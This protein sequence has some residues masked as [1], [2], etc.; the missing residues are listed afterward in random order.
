MSSLCGLALL[1]AGQHNRLL[2]KVSLQL[3]SRQVLLCVSQSEA[4]EGHSGGHVVQP[5]AAG[6]REAPIGGGVLHMQ[7]QVGLV[8]HPERCA[9]HDL[10]RPA[11]RMHLHT[12][13]GS[14]Q[15]RLLC[16]CRLLTS[17]YS[18]SHRQWDC[19]PSSS[20]GL[21]RRESCI[22]KIARA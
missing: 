19:L 8:D 18:S 13:C 12:V 7:L 4:P 6:H 5:R 20:L 17:M 22:R 10:P 21:C 16:M 2:A 11:V 3:A 14:S 15:D 1:L 9:E